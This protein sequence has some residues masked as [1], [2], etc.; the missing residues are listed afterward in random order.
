[1]DGYRAVI[2]S[3]VKNCLAPYAGSAGGADRST[4]GRRRAATLLPVMSGDL[5]AIAGATIT[6]TTTV[7]NSFTHA[8]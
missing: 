3:P 1:M 4:P 6:R 7:R 5:D 8:E 2:F